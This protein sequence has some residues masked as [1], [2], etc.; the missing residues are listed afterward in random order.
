M[1]QPKLGKGPGSR[2]PGLYLSQGWISCDVN[3]RGGAGHRDPD[4]I[5]LYDFCI[6]LYY[7]CVY[8]Y[9]YHGD[10]VRSRTSLQVKLTSDYL[11]PHYMPPDET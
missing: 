10:E 5:Q 8:I 11:P 4:D 3:S 1:L 9:I 2:I 6:S 7:I